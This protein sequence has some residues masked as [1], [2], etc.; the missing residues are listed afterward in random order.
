MSDALNFRTNR[1]TAAQICE[2]LL[3][4][5]RAFY[6]P[7]EQRLPIGEYANK[8][9]QRAIRFEAWSQRELVGLVAAYYDDNVSLRAFITNVSVVPEWQGQGVASSLMAQC[10]SYARRICFRR[11]ELEVNSRNSN[12]VTLYK[13]CGFVIHGV[14]D[15]ALKMRLSID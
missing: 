6:P 11:I 7:L 3:R 1:A 2:H 15:E 8:I 5:N 9:A 14:K 4:C 13:R 12:A 10:I